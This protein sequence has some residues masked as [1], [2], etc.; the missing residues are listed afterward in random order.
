MPTIDQPS[1]RAS[2]R[3]TAPREVLTRILLLCGIA[4]ALLYV[5]G[6]DVLAAGRFPGYDRGAQNISELAAIGSPARALALTLLPVA[7]ALMIAFGLGVWRSSQGGRSLHVAGG[8]IVACGLVG[9]LSLP[10][11]MT[12]RAQLIA[13]ASMPANDIGHIVLTAATVLLIVAMMAFAA[14]PSSTG[15][16]AYSA[17]SA[18]TVLAFGALTGT[19]AP[20]LAAGAPTPYMGLYERISIGAW[21][22]WMVVLAAVLLAGTRADRRTS[23]RQ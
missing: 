10:F 23:A 7:T 8:L 6:N 21:L 4:Y 9:L 17:L 13:G 16:R 14:A 5:V 22:L 19:Q 2:T 12:A 11:P 3:P 20:Q 18:L 1:P 15:F